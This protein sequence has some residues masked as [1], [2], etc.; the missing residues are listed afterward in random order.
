MSEIDTNSSIFLHPTVSFGLEV[1][2]LVQE[3]DSNLEGLGNLIIRKI[4]QR[5]VAELAIQHSAT[6]IAETEDNDALKAIPKRKAIE[7]ENKTIEL[8]QQTLEQLPDEV[9]I[10]AGFALFMALQNNPQ[11]AENTL[12]YKTSNYTNLSDEAR[13]IFLLLGV[14]AVE[15][16][17]QNANSLTG[18]D[19]HIP[20]SLRGMQ[21]I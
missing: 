12:F 9:I 18:D 16:A 4:N 21:M 19:A 14:C 7:K 3:L 15:R 17:L 5:G 8:N 2:A 6:V 20:E 11:A 10:N 13:T 1:L